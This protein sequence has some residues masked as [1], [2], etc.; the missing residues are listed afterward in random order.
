MAEVRKVG[1]LGCGLMGGGI[2]QVCATAGFETV[3]READSG[4]L[5]RGSSRSTTGMKWPSCAREPPSLPAPTWKTGSAT[6]ARRSK[7]GADTSIRAASR[8]FSPAA[9]RWG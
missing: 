6:L 9:V 4:P 3:V 2:A 1:V 7:A 8:L 5:K